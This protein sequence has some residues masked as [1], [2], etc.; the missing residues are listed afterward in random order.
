MKNGEK[1]KTFSF[2]FKCLYFLKK[3]LGI[4]P[5][6]LIKLALLKRNWMVRLTKKQFKKKVF[7]FSRILDFKQQIRQCVSR[8]IYAVK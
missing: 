2:F 7:F 1:N 4:N 3:K 5:I 6:F 8:F